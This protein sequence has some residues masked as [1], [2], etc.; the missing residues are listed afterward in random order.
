MSN[1]FEVAIECGANLV[2]VGSAIF[3]PPPATETAAQEPA[4]A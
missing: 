4:E 2:R 3:G 1:D